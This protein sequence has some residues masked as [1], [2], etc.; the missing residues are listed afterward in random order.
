MKP[1]DNHFGSHATLRAASSQRAGRDGE[2]KAWLCPLRPR[3]MVPLQPSA[4]LVLAA[5][6]TTLEG[7][8]GNQREAGHE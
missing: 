7:Q 8:W 6:D 3:V 2:A 5:P 1:R 4:E